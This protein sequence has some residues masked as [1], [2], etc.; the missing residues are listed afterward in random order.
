M[1]RHPVTSRPRSERHDDHGPALGL[2][3]TATLDRTDW[4]VTRSGVL[5]GDKVA[6]RFDV[7]ALRRP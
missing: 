3:G 7:S 5:I 1:N 2:T 4:G 6:L